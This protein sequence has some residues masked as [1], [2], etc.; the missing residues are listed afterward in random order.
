[1][2]AFPRLTEIETQIQ[3]LQAEAEKMREVSNVADVALNAIIDTRNQL[4]ELSVTEKELIMWQNKVVDAVGIVESVTVQATNEDD[5]R[6][7]K[8]NEEIKQE[9]QN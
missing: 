8:E 4:Q 5:S 2:F 3:A 1:M 9:L 7:E 6:I